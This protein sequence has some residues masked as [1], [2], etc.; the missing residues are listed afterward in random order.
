M[1]E[2]EINFNIGDIVLVV[3]GGN[4]ALGARNLKGVVCDRDEALSQEDIYGGELM[5]KIAL[6]YIRVIDEPSVDIK[7]YW[8]LCAGFKCI[9]I[10]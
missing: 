2:D 5:E 1:N 10:K 4:G 8:G 9:K 3:N 7:Q 6:L